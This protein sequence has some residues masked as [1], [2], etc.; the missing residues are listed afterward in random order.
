MRIASS[1]AKMGLPETSLGVI[2]G[3]GGT[4]R[5][6]QLIGRGRATELIITGRMMNAEE[7]LQTGL[8]TQV[9]A[10]ED[11]LATAASLAE[12]SCRTLPMVAQALK[13]VA[14][15]VQKESMVLRKKLNALAP[16]LAILNLSKEPKPF[17]EA[18]G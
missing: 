17:R 15:H 8:V 1:N 4:Q 14:M 13:A 12:K 9:V 10:Q 6:P 2:P 3:Y 18:K 11:L 7:A 16:V 5:L